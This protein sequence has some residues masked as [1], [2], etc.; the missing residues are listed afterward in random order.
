MLD[1]PRIMKEAHATGVAKGFHDNPRPFGTAI[2]LMHSELSEALEAWREHEPDQRVAE[3]LADCVIR[4]ADTA[5][6]M[7]LPDMQQAYE[8]ALHKVEISSGHIQEFPIELAHAH[9]WLSYA[10]RTDEIYHGVTPVAEALGNCL[11]RVSWI[12]N[13]LDLD[14]A[15]AVDDKMAVNRDR[16]HMHGG[17]RA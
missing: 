14:L 13:Q 2:T 10:W 15:Q 5:E 1:L 4:I 8:K 16:P 12:C 17:K 11:A 6:A 9:Y 3:E 7:D